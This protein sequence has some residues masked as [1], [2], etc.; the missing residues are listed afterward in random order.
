MNV[1]IINTSYR[2]GGAA[3]AASRLSAALRKHCVSASMLVLDNGYD[4][5]YV[6]SVVHG[7][8]S[9]I[10]SRLRF[11]WE[12]I[13]IYLHNHFNRSE[14][15][16]V[17]IADTG[18][19]V[20]GYDCVKKADVIHLHWVNQGFLSLGDLDKLLQLGKPVVWTMHDMWPFTG[21]CHHARKCEYF[22]EKCHNCFYLGG[23][24]AHDLSADIY[25]KKGKIYAKAD[26][27]F[28]GCSNWIA[29]KA[30]KSGLLAGKRVLSIPN[31]IDT[32]LFRPMDKRECREHMN[33]PS[34]KRLILFGALNVTDER[35][36]VAYLLRALSMIER[37]VELV[38]FGQVKSDIR[39]LIP[40]PVHTLGYLSDVYSIVSL[41][42]SV[43]LFVTS[44]LD[45]NLPNMIM[46]SMACGTPCVGFDTG[47]I[48]EMIDHLDNGYVAR[49]MNV[50]DLAKG[51][52]WVLNHPDRQR[53]AE[54]CVSKVCKCYSEEVVTGRYI[55]LYKEVTCQ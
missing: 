23:N 28:V 47:G 16:R 17:S 22:Q 48:P 33:L 8:L 31:P 19:D 25:R 14:L 27:S 21:I 4:D 26:I 9:R 49:Y 45:E 1:L 15:F 13:F 37:D 36:G 52:N 44:S 54:A 7:R 29:E 46:E 11:Y 12:R 53:L 2:T 40:V 38:V 3:V 35:K 10:V 55:E 41:Y 50:A 42:N 20:S 5:G 51:I 32:S 43:D 24:A 39:T 6:E 30:K 34:D 18:T